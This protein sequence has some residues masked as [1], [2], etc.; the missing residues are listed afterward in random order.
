V[1]EKRRTPAS[2]PN[3]NGIFTGEKIQESRRIPQLGGGACVKHT[4][5]GLAA[6]LAAPGFFA[7]LYFFKILY[8]YGYASLTQTQEGSL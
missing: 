4:A 5:A 8:Y 6:R 7:R 1:K 2:E 3:G